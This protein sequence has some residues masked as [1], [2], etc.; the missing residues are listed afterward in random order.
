MTEACSL[1][2]LFHISGNCRKIIVHFLAAEGMLPFNL[3]Q[4]A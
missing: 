3:I 4:L 1:R 2:Q